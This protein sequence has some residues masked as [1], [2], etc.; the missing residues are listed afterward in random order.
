V[1]ERRFL[2]IMAFGG[3]E[4]S[5]AVF[6][7]L[8]NIPQD[9]YSAFM[10][11]AKI[12]LILVAIAVTLLVLF[13]Q[14]IARIYLIAMGIRYMLLVASLVLFHLFFVFQKSGYSE[15]WILISVIMAV[16]AMI[17]V[18]A[19]ENRRWDA[20]FKIWQKIRKIDI[21]KKRFSVLNMFY[22]ITES[23]MKRSHK[24]SVTQLLVV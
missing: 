8:L 9:K 13:F 17:I 1:T 10:T 20:T 22:P 16:I 24:K 12:I 6:I 21:S 4:L 5:L 7:L 14:K 18:I 19:K 2:N 3:M 11:N 23:K 15:I